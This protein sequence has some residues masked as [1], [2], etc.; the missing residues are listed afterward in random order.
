MLSAGQ[1]LR[2]F[3]CS[4]GLAAWGCPS[5]RRTLEKPG[6]RIGEDDESAEDG[7]PT[8]I[9]VEGMVCR[10]ATRCTGQ[11]LKEFHSVFRA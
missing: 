6:K 5:L 8:Q 9:G 4:A 10:H 7:D 1:K 11:R 2:N 3:G